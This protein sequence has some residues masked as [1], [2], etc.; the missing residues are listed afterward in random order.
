MIGEEINLVSSYSTSY[1]ETA[2]VH[3]SSVQ[4]TGTE[5]RLVDCSY[6]SGGSGSGVSL[7][8]YNYNSGNSYCKYYVIIIGT[9]QAIV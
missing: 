1:R 2:P 8:C 4:C 7:G 3:M 6:I 5:S 9:S